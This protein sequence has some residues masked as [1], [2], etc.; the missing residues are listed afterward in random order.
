VVI[1][2]ALGKMMPAI[3]GGL[4]LGFSMGLRNKEEL[5]VSH[6]FCEANFEE[7]RH[8][9]CL[10]LCLEAVLGLKINLVKSE[11]RRVGDVGD[12]EG[13]AHIV[14]CRVTSL[15]LKY[16][17]QPLGASYKAA[18]IW[19]GII[20]KVECRL[21]GWKMLYLLK[22]CR[23]TLIKKHSFQLPSYY[24]SVCPIPVGVL[25]GLN[26]FKEIF[27]G[28]ELVMSLSSI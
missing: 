25:I 12:V 14:G 5:L 20:E 27:Y 19:N 13:W 21:G 6:L 18:F 26:D 17:D 8:L 24:M 15:L 2:E 11:L 4:L 3:M 28:V 9:Q 22:G 16:L 7:L 1:L 10:F 23:L